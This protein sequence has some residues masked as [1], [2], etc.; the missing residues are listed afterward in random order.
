[1]N[2]RRERNAAARAAPRALAGVCSV[3]VLLFSVACLGTL[4]DDPDAQRMATSPRPELGLPLR[5]E[6]P[7]W[8]LHGH[9]GWCGAWEARF[10]GDTDDPAVASIRAARFATA[11]AARQAFPRLTPEFLGLLMRDRIIG[12]PATFEYPE[13][14]A[15]DDVMTA[16]YEVRLPPGFPPDFG[17]RGQ[18]TAVRAANTIFLVETIGVGPDRLVPAVLEL[19][20]AAY[21]RASSGCATTPRATPKATPR[22][23]PG[24]SD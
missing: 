15:G 8:L 24:L 18:F 23:S 3:A 1:M 7:H 12:I 14:L 19:A 4:R 20:R 5:E 16:L 22:A 2:R 11:D 21:R 10:G 13:P 6:H 17:L 9:A